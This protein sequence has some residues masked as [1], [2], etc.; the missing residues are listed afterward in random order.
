MRMKIM[1]LALGVLVLALMQSV[2]AEAAQEF[3]F[4]AVGVRQG[5]FK[6]ESLRKGFEGKITGLTFD[7]SV[8]S[9][10]DLATGQATGKRQHRPI[11]IIKPWGASSTQFFTALVTNEVLSNVT[12]DFFSI[13]V[14]TGQMVLDHT[15]KL[16]NATVTSIT[17]HSDNGVLEEKLGKTPPY[18]SIELTFQQI[19]ILD[20]LN[21][22]AAMDSW[23]AIA[24]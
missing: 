18:E 6:G 2:V 16:T 13:S 5:V 14:T 21:K 24:P 10:R 7:Y 23:L 3:Y 8:V 1:G 22:G 4:S 9:P 11:R 15:V 20:H 19:E 12:I 17:H